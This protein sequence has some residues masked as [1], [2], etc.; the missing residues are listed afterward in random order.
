LPC[1]AREEGSDNRKIKEGRKGTFHSTVAAI[2]INFDSFSDPSR[3]E[4][5]RVLAK[6]HQERSGRMSTPVLYMNSK[7]NVFRQNN[8]TRQ[9]I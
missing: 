4:V 5:L 8:K 3:N 6:K 1:S 2:Y 7:G 9:R